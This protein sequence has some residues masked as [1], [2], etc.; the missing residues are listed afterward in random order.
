MDNNMTQP[1]DYEFIRCTILVNRK[2]CKYK[3]KY[4]ELYKSFQ[5]QKKLWKRKKE[6]FHGM[7]RWLKVS[8]QAYKEYEVLCQN[9][10]VLKE[11][12]KDNVFVNITTANGGKFK[13]FY[14][15][16]I[17]YYNNYC[18]DRIAITSQVIMWEM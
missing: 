2:V 13:G 10:F 11:F 6:K 9:E 3:E 15:N 12:P 5:E 17:W 16:G 4:P 7:N 18:K 1:C 14:L 8:A